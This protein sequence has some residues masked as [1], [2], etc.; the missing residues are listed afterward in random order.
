MATFLYTWNPKKWNWSDLQEA[1]YHVNNHKPYDMRWSCGNTKRISLGDAFFLIRL[2]VEP[3][4]IIGYVTSQ[5]Y[6]FQHWDEGQA[7][8]GKEIL[9][10][11]LLFKSL[12]DVPIFSIDYLKKIIH[13]IIGLLRLEAYRFQIKLPTSYFRFYNIVNL[14]LNH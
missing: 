7:K 5:P 4:G 2:G 9:G 3:K 10:T 6:L 1:I 13:I 12:S 11:D 14:P 8:Q